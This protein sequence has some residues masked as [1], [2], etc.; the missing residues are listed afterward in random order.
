VG[1]IVLMCV[2]SRGNERRKRSKEN[3]AFVFKGKGRNEFMG[4]ERGIV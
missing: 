2:C 3:K 1:Y 4:K